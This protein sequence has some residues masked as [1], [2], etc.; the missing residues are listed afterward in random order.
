MSRGVEVVGFASGGV[1]VEMRVGGRVG[2][3]F[4]FGGRSFFG[5]FGWRA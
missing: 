1:G 2:F 4:V 5:G 3:V